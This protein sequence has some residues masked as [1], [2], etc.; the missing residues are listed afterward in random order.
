MLKLTALAHHRRL[1]IAL[2]GLRPAQRLG[3]P[4]RQLQAQRAQI[5]HKGLN[6][7]LI[8]PGI[9]V[10]HHR[11]RR[12]AQQGRVRHRPALMMDFLDHDH[13]LAYLKHRHLHAPPILQLHRTR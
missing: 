9:G 2:D 13:G 7:R 12:A 10:L 5:V 1:A 6:I 4:F 11:Q 3:E 8:P